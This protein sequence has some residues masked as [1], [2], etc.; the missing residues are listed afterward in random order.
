ML[1]EPKHPSAPDGKGASEFTHVGLAC[2]SIF[3]FLRFSSSLPTSLR[4]RVISLARYCCAR[5]SV[6]GMVVEFQGDARLAQT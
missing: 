1:A 3:A 2:L 6:K 5:A 4:L